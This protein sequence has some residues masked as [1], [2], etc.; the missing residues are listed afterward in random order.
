M[1][2]QATDAAGHPVAGAAITWAI[3]QGSGTLSNPSA[4]TDSNGLANSGFIGTSLFGNSFQAATVTVSSAS[5][6]VNFTITTVIFS[7]GSQ[8]GSGATIHFIA[9]SEN[10]NLSAPSGSTL[11]AAV[12]IAVSAAYGNQV[13]Q[14]IPNISLRI[15]GQDLT[16]PPLASCNGPKGVVLTDSTGTATCDLLVT[17]PPGT[18]QLRSYVGEYQQGPPFELQITPGT[19][20][21]YSLPAFNQSF[22][23]TAASGT[24]NVVTTAGCGWSASSNVSWIS[25]TAGSSGTGNGTVSYSVAADSG[26]SRTGTLSIAGQTYTVS[27]T[28]TTTGGLAVA[29]VNLPA[30]TL[31]VAYSA[32]LSATG[33]QPPYTWSTSGSLPAGLTLSA[34]TGVIS[35]TPSAAGTSNFT[36]TVRDSTGA[37]AS[38]NFSITVNGVTSSSFAITT[39]SLA[40]GAVGTAY[41]QSI[42]TVN[43]NSCGII[44]SIVTFS[45][46]AGTLPNGLALQPGGVISGTPTLPG[47][48]SF[49]LTATSQCLNTA[50]ASLK[51]TITGNAP[52]MT[53][54]PSALAFTVQQGTSNI[55]ADQQIAISSSG[56]A[57]TYTA[58]ASTNSGANWL[59]VK[60]QASGSTPANATIGVVNY[61]SLAP[62][63]YTGSIGI[64]S[65][66]AN[67]PASVPVTL[68]VLAAVP[69]TVSP[70]TFAINQFVTQGSNVAK[71]PITVSNGSASSSFSAAAATA[72]G[73]PWLSISP[74]AGSTPASLT[75]SADSGGL[76]TGVYTGTIVITPASGATQTISVTLVVS[77][78]PPSIASIQNAASFVLG[79][80]APGEIVTIF[81]SAMGPATGV[82]WQL[83]PAGTVATNLAST[84]VSFD[85][86]AAPL[87]YAAAGQVSAVVPYEVAGNS[88]TKVQ[89]SYLGLVSNPLTVQVAGAAPGIFTANS[90]GSG[91]GAILNQD[92]SV[93]SASNGAAPGSVVSIF[94]T[95]EGQTNPPGIDGA[96][97][98]STLPLPAPLLP[99]TAQIAGQ[100]AQVMYYGAAPGELAGVLQVNAVI[101]A[102]VQRG[103]SVPVVIQVGSASSQTVTLFIKP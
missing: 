26:A 98:A 18:T 71:Q 74:A 49:T 1:V 76:A 66:A 37:S 42:M 41:Q 94:A 17:G 30:G 6:S 2:V 8:L 87:I 69:L 10:L 73:G 23:S 89:L 52:Q 70:L 95:G 24:V 20:C 19:S 57:L 85:G 92:F 16:S 15:I 65:Q 33:G 96:I 56:A 50:S 13:G 82:G 81:G 4:A 97:N 86:V 80:V 93:N 62:G 36:G 12:Q 53:A 14:P 11:P 88:T 21:S 45:L 99:V 91:Q 48:F 25:I 34:S 9:P 64:S 28:G 67:S 39:T 7:N 60:N 84:S 55:P 43:A 101:P 77:Q 103:T 35:G 32:T 61:S 51:I 38:Q 54:S 78:Q 72:N 100:P 31:N 68:T 90:L 75:A 47:T 40:N 5:A 102:N 83:T 58:S 3:T 46:S 27:Q 22:G 59:T 29:S 63:P 44:S 79:P